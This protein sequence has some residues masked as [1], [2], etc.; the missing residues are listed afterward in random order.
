MNTNDIIK[1]AL[2]AA[3][4]YLLYKKVMEMSGQVPPTGATTGTT[5]TATTGQQLTPL[6]SNYPNQPPTT[7]SPIQPIPTSTGQQNMQQME[8]KPDVPTVEAQALATAVNNRA[9]QDNSFQARGGLYN[10]DE[11]SWFYGQ[12]TGGSAGDWESRITDGSP[13]ETRMNLYTWLG[14]VGLLGATR[15]DPERYGV[16]GM[17]GMGRSRNLVGELR[18]GG[19]TGYE[20]A[21]KT[22]LQ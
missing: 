8:P 19:A 6:P 18:S 7:T 15:G 4:A 17:Q 16:G 3:A 1:Y 9:M 5:T 14:Y 12:I 11:W 20:R 21:K 13:R 22:W 2:M 10:Y